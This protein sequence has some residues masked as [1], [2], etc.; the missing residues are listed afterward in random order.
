MQNKVPDYLCISTKTAT[1]IADKVRL[2]SHVTQPL[3]PVAE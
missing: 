1:F 3:Y 2:C